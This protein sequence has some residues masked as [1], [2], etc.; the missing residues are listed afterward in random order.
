MVN[1]NTC[2]WYFMIQGPEEILQKCLGVG[3][4]PWVGGI[5]VWVLHVVRSTEKC[6][7]KQLTLFTLVTHKEGD[8]R[9]CELLS[10]MDSSSLQFPGQEKEGSPHHLQPEILSL[11]M[12]GN[13]D[14]QTRYS[15]IDFRLLST[16]SHWSTWLI[17][18]CP[19]IGYL[20]WGC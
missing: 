3:T 11:G 4:T 17:T 2:K 5:G 6:A 9:L 1:N 20:F 7:C 12:L 18:M 10:S 19:N 14:I 8:L 13:F 16:I 15:S